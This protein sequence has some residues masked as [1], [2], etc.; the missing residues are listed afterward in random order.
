[1]GFNHFVLAY[2]AFASASIFLAAS[3][4]DFIQSG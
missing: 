1:M 4:Q 2:Q 3:L